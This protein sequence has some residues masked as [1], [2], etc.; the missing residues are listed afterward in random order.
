MKHKIFEILV[1]LSILM[2]LTSALSIGATTIKTNKNSNGK[3]TCSDNEIYIGSMKINA[4]KDDYEKIRIETVDDFLETNIPDYET[5][6]KLTFNAN[7]EIENE[8]GDNKERWVFKIILK[9]GLGPNSAV[10]DSYTEKINDQALQS[11]AQTGKIE[12]STEITR[13][14]YIGMEQRI[15]NFR[16]ELVAEYYKGSWFGGDLNLEVEDDDWG[17]L[18]T[19]L[20]NQRPAIP[21]VTGPSEGS[22]NEPHTFKATA[23]DSDGD[24]IKYVFIWGNGRSSETDFMSSG[25]TGT[26]S[27]TWTQ[28]GNYEV[29]VFTYDRFWDCSSDA[30]TFSFSAPRSISL[31]NPILNLLLHR[32]PQLERVLNLF[33]L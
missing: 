32:Y 15:R 3:L 24:Q 4:K 23:S 9:D 29:E 20:Y 2:L 21:T 17:I 16:V 5:K 7:Y 22:I 25:E 30:A 31:E 19:E 8:D 1:I 33:K 14:S 13:A 6:L 18:E 28:Q 10:I 11:D 27:Y 26:V 12:V